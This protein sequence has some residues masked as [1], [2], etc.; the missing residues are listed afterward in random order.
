MTNRWAACRMSFE[1]TQK[2][3]SSRP[4]RSPASKCSFWRAK[5]SQ[6]SIVSARTGCVRKEWRFAGR[7]RH[8]S[9][10]ACGVVREHLCSV[11][12]TCLGALSACQ[13]PTFRSPMGL[14][15]RHRAGST[16]LACFRHCAAVD[17][18]RMTWRRVAEHKNRRDRLFQVE[19]YKKK[20]IFSINYWKIYKKSSN[21]HLRPGTLCCGGLP[22]GGGG[23]WWLIDM[24]CVWFRW[25]LKWCGSISCSTF[26]RDW[27]N[28][29]KFTLKIVV[30]VG[31]F[32][33]TKMKIKD[34]VREICLTENIWRDIIEIWWDKLQ[35]YERTK[36]KFDEI[37]WL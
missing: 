27:R 25:K 1:H 32:S 14:W 29:W 10:R 3:F 2:V 33:M 4:A 8:R 31:I 24:A 37:W 19:F 11:E 20:F 28:S 26:T 21:F 15:L 9:D 35:S 12:R 13:C 36:W 30:A 17:A 16:R 22:V 34:N 6:F 18:M 23:G 7:L 5:V